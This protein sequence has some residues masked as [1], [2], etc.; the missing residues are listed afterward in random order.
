MCI[1]FFSYR[2]NPDYELIVASNRDE[3]LNRPTRELHR[4]EDS[5]AIVAGL[6][7]T[8]GGTWLGVSKTKFGL[9]TN[10]RDFHNPRITGPS[11]GLL[12][13]DY[14]SESTD[15]IN[16][17][18]DLEIR[19]DA[20]DGYNLVIAD[21][22][23]LYYQSNKLAGFKKLEP[24]IYGLSN[25]FL[26]SQWPKVTKGKRIFTDLI[27]RDSFVDDLIELMMDSEKFPDESLPD[28]GI[29]SELEHF[30]SS[31]FIQGKEYGTRVT[32]ILTKDMAGN[33][34]ITEHNHITNDRI[35][36]NF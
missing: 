31:I 21:S 19:K 4:W 26:D 17:L 35:S 25:A 34:N 13:K 23:S 3:F 6:D 29:G 14:L 28:T 33:I 10:Y 27:N 18:T 7:Q 22:D 8:H 30:L 32:T 2:S 24:G 15:A 16:F 20:Y 5:D 1:A 9:L 36:I 12:L 11:R